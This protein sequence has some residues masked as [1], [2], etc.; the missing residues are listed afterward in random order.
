MKQIMSESGYLRSFDLSASYIETLT[1]LN[2]DLIKFEVFA[3]NLENLMPGSTGSEEAS[4][5][6]H[7]SL[8]GQKV[9]IYQLFNGYKSLLS[10]AWSLPSRWKSLFNVNF[11]MFDQNE[12]V[13]LSNGWIVRVESLGAFSFDLSAQAEISLWSQTGESKLRLSQAVVVQQKLT[14]LND[15]A[16]VVSVHESEL[17]GEIPFVFELDINMAESPY[18][19]CIKMSHGKFY[20]RFS[21]IL[22]SFES[23]FWPFFF[24]FYLHFKKS[25][26]MKAF[27]ASS[28]DTKV[29][30]L[31]S[32]QMKRRPFQAASYM[33][34]REAV[35]YC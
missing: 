31:E 21:I 7:L 4:M 13:R 25:Q 24:L 14:L 18:Q 16:G 30:Q 1:R 35:K 8:M 10:L 15:L 20:L 2:L 19:M 17:S 28:L 11:L 26:K 27:T 23:Y 9:K 32:E 29:L 3:N 6:V 33:L 34:A 22:L 5:S 12:H